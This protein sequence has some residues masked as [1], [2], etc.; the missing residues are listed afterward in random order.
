MSTEPSPSAGAVAAEFTLEREDRNWSPEVTRSKSVYVVTNGEVTLTT[1][2][3][4]PKGVREPQST[5]ATFADTKEVDALLA[6]IRA[7][8]DDTKPAKPDGAKSRSGCLIEGKTKRCS[9]VTDGTTP[10]L[11]ALLKLEQVLIVHL[12][13]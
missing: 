4:G 13:R 8:R 10:R 9:T 1:E 2:S 11:E 6:I 12:F 7:T 3:S 5:T